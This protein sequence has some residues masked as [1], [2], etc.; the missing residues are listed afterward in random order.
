[1]RHVI[2]GGSIAGISAAGAIRSND[3]AAEI[4]LLSPE[5]VKPYYRPM[6]ASI[7]EK[8]DADITLSDDPREKYRI[9]TL[10]E[11]AV[12]LD[13][14]SKEVTL[15]SGRRQAYDKLLIA[16]GRT[17]VIPE[18][19]AGLRGSDVYTLRT[20]DDARAIQAAA[21]RAK[22]AVVLGGGIVG[23]KAAVALT[24]RGLA[25]TLIEKHSRILSGKLDQQ[26]SAFIT[27]LLKRENIDVVT[28][29]QEYEVLRTA[30]TLQSI[31]LAPGRIINA[32]FIIVALESKP[33][34]DAFKTS[35][36][37]M[38]KG[39]LVRETLETN[40]PDVYAAG[41][42][43]E[44][45]DLISN[46]MAV[47]AL[48][49]NAKEM[50]R[51]AGMNMAGSQVRYEG[52]LENRYITDIL[53]VPVATLGLVDPEDSTCEMFIASDVSFYRKTVFKNDVMV[54][55]LF[56]NNSEDTGVYSYLIR[57]RIPL[58]K[59]K[60]LAVRGTLGESRYLKPRTFPF[61]RF[62]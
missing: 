57:N 52:F 4:I 32:D 12:D 8:D 30:G 43:V 40:V 41:D 58:G 48:W 26:G 1:M 42:V 61:S 46:S 33:N 62:Q 35:G 47:S 34:I 2:M 36:I 23:I 9:R 10:T 6:I 28:N 49:E 55:A 45:R 53:D 16:T 25:V 60:D 50:G 18:T 38:N 56:I 15:S 3:A 39:I 19:I 31:R 29:Q 13:V 54:G 51:V 22:N 20:L 11:K 17:P 5:R 7:I 37:S 24:R 14:R 44:Y 21:K 59:L 27:G